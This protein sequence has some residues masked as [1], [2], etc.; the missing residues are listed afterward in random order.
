MQLHSGRQQSHLVVPFQ[1]IVLLGKEK[2]VVCNRKH[3][4]TFSII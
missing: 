2:S 4:D 3:L 1:G